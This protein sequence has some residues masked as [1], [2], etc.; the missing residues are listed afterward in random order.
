MPALT[1]EQVL[2]EEAKSIHGDAFRYQPTRSNADGWQLYRALH[3]LS[4][5]ALCLSG[6]GIRSA[7]FA[8]GV[9]EALAVHPRQASTR[10]EGDKQ[11][12]SASA[13]LLSQFHYLSTV[14]G[15]GYIGSWLAAWIARDGYGA[16]WR[17]LVGRREHPEQE[18]AEIAWL[19][20]YSN[21][22]T[23]R[24]GLFSADTWTAIAL[25]VRNLILNWLVILPA[26]VLLLLSIKAFAVAAFWLSGSG[27]YAIVALAVVGALSM[28]W[29]LRFALLNRPSRDPCFEPARAARLSSAGAY[30]P[31]KDD[32][33]LRDEAARVRPGA[34]EGKFLKLALVP[35]VAAA[36]L[37]SLYLSV[38]APALK[39]WQLWTTAALATLI[40][41]ATYAIGWIA[42]A[43]PWTWR[44]CKDETRGFRY[45]LRDFASWS[46]GGGGFYGAIVGLGVHLFAKFEPL[47][48]IGHVTGARQTGLFLIALIYGVPWI[49]T[50]QLTAEMIFVGLSSWQRFSDADREWFGRSTGWFT[51]TAFAWFAAAFLVFVVANLVWALV[52]K[53]PSAQY[54]SSLLAIAAA[55]FGTLG[56]NSG[57]SPA[58]DQT[59]KKSGRFMRIALPIAAVIFLVLLV[60]AVSILIDYLLFGHN[61]VDTSLLG[62]GPASQWRQNWLWLLVGFGVVIAVASAAWTHVNIN[63]FSAHSLYRNR[64]IRAYLGASNP[65]RAPNPFTGFD[66]TDNMRMAEL[67]PQAAGAWLPF[68]VI[69]IA[70]NVVNSKRLAWQERKATPFT[71]TSLHC[72][73]AA[74]RLGYRP[75]AQYG[76]EMRGGLSLGT[77]LAISGAA[78][79]PNMG[80]HSSPLVTLLLALFNVRLGWWLGNPG[81]KGDDSYRRDG[82]RIAIRP[83]IFEMF[84]LTTDDRKYIYLSD[85]GHF[86]NLGLYEMIRRRCR[87]VVVSDA[88]CD[89][90][91]GFE[92]L[93]NAVRKIAIDLGV[94]I[95]FGK[96]RELKSRSKDGAVIEGAY[97]AIGVI[98]YKSAPEWNTDA[99]QETT[100]DVENGYILYIKPGYHGNESAGIVAYATANAAFPHETTADQFFSESQFES[101]RTLGF[102]IMDG[103]LRQATRNCD[104]ISSAQTATVDASK[105]CDLIRA[106]DSD[107]IKEAED[108]YASARIKTPADALKSLN[109]DDLK[110]LFYSIFS[111]PGDDA[112]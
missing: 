8:L 110:A 83:F 37:L 3:R 88:A 16:V 108:A 35:A 19:R 57:K 94:Y 30:A 78:A 100:R 66:D 105:L 102:E 26:L 67:R 81:E 33:P 92:D 52:A 5:V 39:D 91:F 60:L 27:R 42:A 85:G 103:V 54:G 74:D 84:G 20:T 44:P 68:H 25:Y 31:G 99:E 40:G 41:M 104:T 50:A 63:R 24:L 53:Y 9:I 90:S 72:G 109:E 49:I 70:L 95:S 22:L 36:L 11:A 6:G 1:P 38:R 7:S 55:A 76:G 46:I 51:V 89:P 48:L 73:T 21:Y 18:P 13:S 98:D 45:W 77:A 75:T 59:D 80:Y 58:T 12:A 17:G 2:I 61:L 111:R 65:H 4:S 112:R 97:Y 14:S 79:S 56:G 64:L 62:A 93:G 96:L 43:P 29:S 32:D 101:Y 34:D 86:E 15:G 10:Q 47:L 87:F 71:A 23:P 107:I 106:L 82:P 28:M 69:N